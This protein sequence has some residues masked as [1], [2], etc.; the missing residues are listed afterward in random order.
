MKTV[1]G[2]KNKM[3]VS[4]VI[5]TILMVAITV[6]LAAVLYVMV[7]GL[8]PGNQ[9]TNVTMVLQ[10]SSTTA[11]N[12]S[13]SVSSITSANVDPAQL[14]YLVENGGITYYSGAAGLN[15]VTSGVTVNVSYSDNLDVSHV[16]AG[17]SIRLTTT[18]SNPLHGGTFKVFFSNAAISTATIP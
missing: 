17:D 16:S 14:T 11:A 4:P 9:P 15:A 12:F 18:P 7:A 2:R 3:A 5:G 8:G 1:F 10:G 13:F 6:V